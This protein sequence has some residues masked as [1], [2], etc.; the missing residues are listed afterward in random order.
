MIFF[1]MLLKTLFF[2]LCVDPA[3]YEICPNFFCELLACKCYVSLDTSWVERD[4]HRTLFKR[5]LFGAF[6]LLWYSKPASHA[7]QFSGWAAPFARNTRLTWKKMHMYDSVPSN[8][9]RYSIWDLKHRPS[10]SPIG[11]R[12]R[13]SSSF[14]YQKRTNIAYTIWLMLLIVAMSIGNARCRYGVTFG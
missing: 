4:N 8:F 12:M 5:A 2:S 11:N 3:C 9:V 7:C 14:P 10:Y 13:L 6:P 1:Y